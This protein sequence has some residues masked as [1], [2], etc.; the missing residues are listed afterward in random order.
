MIKNQFKKENYLTAPR[1][2]VY[3]T[4]GAFSPTLLWIKKIVSVEIFAS[5]DKS[6][7]Y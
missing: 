2:R 3:M 1:V 4:V 5:L 7:V 6:S